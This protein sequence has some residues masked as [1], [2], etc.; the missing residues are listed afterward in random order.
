MGATQPRF[1]IF[2]GRLSGYADRGAA[3]ARTGFR[4]R[5]RGGHADW[6]INGWPFHTEPMDPLPLDRCRSGASARICT[7][8]SRAPVAVRAIATRQSRARARRGFAS[9]TATSSD[10]PLTAAACPPIK[11]AGWP[12]T[13]SLWTL[14]A[15]ATPGLS[16]IWVQPRLVTFATDPDNFIDQ[17]PDFT[18]S[19]VP[20]AA[21]ILLGT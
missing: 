3:G 20:D 7:T 18:V 9:P 16:T 12:A 4:V 2:A 17:P 5:R 13:A 14:T 11:E 10:S 19:S 6:V 15:L 21:T 1:R 8:G